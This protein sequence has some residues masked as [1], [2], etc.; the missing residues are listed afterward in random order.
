M[1]ELPLEKSSRRL[2]EAEKEFLRELFHILQSDF[3]AKRKADN[4][5]EAV[6]SRTVLWD[7]ADIRSSWVRCRPACLA[8]TIAMRTARP[9]AVTIGYEIFYASGL[10]PVTSSSAS[11]KTETDW[12]VLAHEIC[13]VMQV[14]KQGYGTVIWIATYFWDSIC[15]FLRGRH[16]YFGNRSEIQGFAVQQAAL[17]LLR[18]RSS[19][20]VSSTEIEQ[21]VRSVYREWMKYPFNSNQKQS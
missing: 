13:H 21:A 20:T 4:R 6:L 3:S 7:Y 1:S 8:A 19:G 16:A 10:P 12:A 15:C 9:Y 17:E 14:A 2:T 5:L 11:Q 18:H